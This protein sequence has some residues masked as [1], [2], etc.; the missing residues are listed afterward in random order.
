MIENLLLPVFQLG[1][2]MSLIEDTLSSMEPLIITLFGFAG[3]AIF[4]LEFYEFISTE[5]IFKEE[6]SY[7]KARKSFGERSNVSKSLNTFISA[8]EYLFL[9]P[10]IVFFWAGVFFVIIVTVSSVPTVET[11]LL[12]SV[13]IVGAIRIC[14]YYRRKIAEDVAKLLPLVLLGN[15]VLDF[16]VISL[17]ETYKTIKTAF[18]DPSFQALALNYFIL[19]VVLEFVL[20]AITF[21]WRRF[22]KARREKE[23]FSET[24]ESEGVVAEETEESE[25]E[26]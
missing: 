24:V 25:E 15:F 7:A 1:G 14:A 3:Y 5:D 4:V 20:R 16:K 26:E 9:F 8:L 18:F 19:L 11:I 2:R 10:F 17:M 12:T 22:K 6:S 21:F 23:E 13:A